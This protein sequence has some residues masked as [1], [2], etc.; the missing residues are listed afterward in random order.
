MK[1][2]DLFEE[3]EPPPG[4]LTRLRSRLKEQRRRGLGRPALAFALAL[5]LVAAAFGALR[6]QPVDLRPAVR[7]SVTAGLIG[8][9]AAGP[10]V[11]LEAGQPAGLQRLPSANPN[12]VLY[13]VAA[14]DPR[15]LP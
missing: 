2:G 11:V 3:L 13:R 9:D 1:R 5:A 14:I 6:T 15:Q 10:S 8:V 12:V 4:G 7:G